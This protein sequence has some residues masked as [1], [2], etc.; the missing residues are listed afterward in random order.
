MAIEQLLANASRQINLGQAAAASAQSGLGL[1]QSFRQT[2]AQLLAEHQSNVAT[3]SAAFEQALRAGKAF[4]VAEQQ[5][6]DNQIRQDNAAAALAN[7]GLA[8]R[9]Q[10]QRFEL[11]QQERQDERQNAQAQAEILSGG[12]VTDILITLTRVV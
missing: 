7:A 5:K 9:A 3:N 1:A 10:A 6:I 12:S 2:D 11:A 4:G 8:Q